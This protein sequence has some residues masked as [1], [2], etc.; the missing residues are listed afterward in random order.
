MSHMTSFGVFKTLQIDMDGLFP[1]E[2][3]L[4]EVPATLK[5]SSTLIQPPLK[6]IWLQ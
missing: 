5:P 4:A 2:R 1:R 3:E 6:Q